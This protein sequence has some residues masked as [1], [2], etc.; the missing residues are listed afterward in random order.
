MVLWHCRG[1][2]AML[3]CKREGGYNGSKCQNGQQRLNDT[4]GSTP[5]ANKLWFTQKSDRWNLQFQIILRPSDITA[6]VSSDWKAGPV[7]LRKLSIIVEEA[8]SS[9]ELI[10]HNLK[11][12]LTLVYKY[13]SALALG[14]GLITLGHLPK[15]L[16]VLEPSSQSLFMFK[17]QVLSKHAIVKMK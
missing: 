1:H 13:N 11:L 17:F 15:A 4:Q 10:I 9:E 5:L 14:L 2:L 7:P 3:N 16:H 12:T 8:T 6:N